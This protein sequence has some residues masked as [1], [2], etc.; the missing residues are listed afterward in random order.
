MMQK[1]HNWSVG[2]SST[3]PH[4]I[5]TMQQIKFFNSKFSFLHIMIVKLKNKV[6]YSNFY[7]Y[8]QRENK[9]IWKFTQTHLLS[10]YLSKPFSNSML[11]TNRK[12]QFYICNLQMNITNTREGSK[13]IFQ[14]AQTYWKCVTGE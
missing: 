10:I 3:T 8:S 14:F 2:C 7:F 6:V 1:L 11:T 12:K 13:F 4:N 9:I 5:L